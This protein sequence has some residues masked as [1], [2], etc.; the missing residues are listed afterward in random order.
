MSTGFWIAGSLAVAG[1]VLLVLMIPAVLR[2]VRRLIDAGAA[3]RT[4]LDPRLTTLRSLVPSRGRP[5][6]SRPE[7]SYR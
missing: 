2:P 7:K 1:V 3:F 4:S 6:K 5:E